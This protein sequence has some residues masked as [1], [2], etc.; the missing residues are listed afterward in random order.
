MTA[1]SEDIIP[2]NYQPILTGALHR[3]LGQND[4]HD[5]LSLYSFSWLRGGRA[6]S[7]GLS[8]PNGA[9]FFI[10]AYDSRFL[11]KIIQ[12]I[13]ESPYIVN[14]LSVREVIVQKN[15]EFTNIENTLLFASPILV[16]RNVNGKDLHFSFD[17]DQSGEYLTE[18]LKRKL[19]LAGLSDDSVFVEFDRSYHSPRTKVI[20][21]NQV[22]NKVN[23]CPVKI[24]GSPEQVTFAWNVGIGNSTGIGFGAVK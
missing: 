3:W 21:Y 8:F 2:F 18:T 16:K 9:H 19:R 23:L 10:S 11:E 6:I 5:G 4:L 14:G 12:N 24:K 7:R 1:E 22:G 20:Y 13:K 15:P 17:D